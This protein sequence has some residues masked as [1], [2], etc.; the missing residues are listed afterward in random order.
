[1]FIYT[2]TISLI[3]LL[4]NMFLRSCDLLFTVVSFKIFII[5]QKCTE[6]CSKH[7]EN[8]IIPMISYIVL[9]IRT[10]FYNY[11][12]KPCVQ[13][14]HHC[15][16]TRIHCFSFPQLLW[17]PGMTVWPWVQ[18]SNSHFL[19]CFLPIVHCGVSGF[20]KKKIFTNRFLQN[21]A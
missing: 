13:S 11:K 16:E 5:S 10:K 8:E 7:F 1:M 4:T 19:S 6:H 15:L 18:S 12:S 9:W 3:S 2:F 14:F 21:E 17:D 20:Q